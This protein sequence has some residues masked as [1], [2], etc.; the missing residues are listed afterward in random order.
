MLIRCLIQPHFTIRL[1]SRPHPQ[2]VQPQFEPH[3]LLRSVSAISQGQIQ[4]AHL[5]GWRLPRCKSTGVLV[6]PC[7]REAPACEQGALDALQARR[8]A[9]SNTVWDWAAPVWLLHLAEATSFLPH[10][11]P[12]AGLLAN[13]N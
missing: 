12:L 9:C 8:P 6:L 11:I 2:S 10:V 1:L 3:G 7:T 5:G 4:G 13:P